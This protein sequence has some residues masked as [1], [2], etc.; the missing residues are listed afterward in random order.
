MLTNGVA[1]PIAVFENPIAQ[2]TYNNERK[3]QVISLQPIRDWIATQSIF[4]GELQFVS[5]DLIG[6]LKHMVSSKIHTICY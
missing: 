1:K 6:T 2:N 5:I 3:K 4:Q